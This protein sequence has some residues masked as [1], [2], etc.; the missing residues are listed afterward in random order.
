MSQHTAQKLGLL[1]GALVVSFW[2]IVRFGTS[3]SAD[4]CG[5]AACWPP[6]SQEGALVFQ[7]NLDNQFP[8]AI[9]ATPEY[10]AALSHA[11]ATALSCSLCAWEV[12]QTCKILGVSCDS[13]VTVTCGP[14][15]GWPGDDSWTRWFIW[16]AQP[17]PAG[18]GSWRRVGDFCAPG[19]GVSVVQV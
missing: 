7:G 19:G 1:A 15:A 17:P 6:P 4:P 9:S 18:T 16:F 5:P 3:A 13:K 14:K 8:G 11:K 12:L 2:I 10:N